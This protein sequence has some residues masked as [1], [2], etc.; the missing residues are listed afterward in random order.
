MNSSN[1]VAA[2]WRTRRALHMAPAQ[3]KRQRERRWHNLQ[4]ALARTPALADL[5]GQPLEAFPVTELAELRNDY[6]LWNSL[7]LSDGALRAMANRAETGEPGEEISAG[8]SSGSSGEQRGLFV[9]GPA[10]RAEYLGQSLARLLPL[11]AVLRGQRLALHLR[12]SNTLYNSVARRHF[13]FTH[14]P[15]DAAPDQ[16]AAALQ[17]YAPT[18]LIAPPHRLLAMAQ[19]G[20]RLPGLRHLFCG[21]EPLSEA[22][23]AFIADFF[24]LHPRHIY[25]A[26]EGFLGA[27]CAMGR[28]HLNDHVLDIRLEQ[29]AGTSGFRPIITDLCRTSQ[30]IVRVR[31]DDYLELDS[32]P[33]PCGFAGRV[34]APIQGRVGDIWQLDGRMVTPPQIVAALDPVL[35]AGQQ[36]QAIAS[37]EGITL[38]VASHCPAVLAEPAT[39]AL[40]ALC[41]KPVRTALDLPAWTGPKR[42]R[43]VWSHG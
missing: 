43:V 20:I 25:Q 28:L 31:G 9:S 22:K 40:S 37:A 26:T 30:P 16:T 18:I 42:R 34:I 8:W 39:Q 19:G 2:W 12:A 15:L 32:R 23:R 36:W 1:V 17:H 6:G 33:C 38:R 4:P 24:H 3:L 29:V 41:R 14:F 5:A 35:G 13:A 10:E 27:D 11:R 21:S 7:G